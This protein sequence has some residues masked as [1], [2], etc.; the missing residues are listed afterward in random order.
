M[1]KGYF[2]SKVEDKIVI[3]AIDLLNG[4]GI[5]GNC[6]DR[7]CALFHKKSQHFDVCVLILYLLKVFNDIF[8]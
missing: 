8:T 2:Q 6:Y 4:V 7:C 1:V 5:V 3:V